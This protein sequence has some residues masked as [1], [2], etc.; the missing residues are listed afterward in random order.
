[1][2]SGQQSMRTLI[3]A[4]LGALCVANA[5]EATAQGPTTSW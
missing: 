2:M 5:G 4:V 3:F 1:M